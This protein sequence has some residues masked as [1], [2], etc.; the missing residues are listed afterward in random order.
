MSS[1]LA[2][3]TSVIVQQWQQQSVI[4]I[5]AVSFAIAYVWLAA[6]ESKWCWPAGFAGTF[7]YTYLYF[8]V[9][10]IFQMLLNVYYMLMAIWGF[11]A[12]KKAGEN[13]LRISRMSWLQHVY[14][15]L[16]GLSISFIVYY[17]AQFWLNYELIFLDIS[18]TI[19]SLLSTYL[20]VAKKLENWFYWSLINLVSI[21][22]LLETGLY[23]SIVLM[24]IYIVIAVKGL[25]Q[26]LHKYNHMDEYV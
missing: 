24:F 15:I 4:E 14:M 21:V 7:L 16:A 2:E 3:V 8:D 9:N 11:I 1:W 10:L 22:L 13:K 20:T 25:K 6:N 23:L 17:I 19:F 26:W 18:V 12:W 5:F